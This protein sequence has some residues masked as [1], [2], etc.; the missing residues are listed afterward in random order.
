MAVRR[1]KTLPLAGPAALVVVTA[2]WA[3]LLIVGWALIYWPHLPNGFLLATEVDPAGRAGLLEAL[4]FSLVTL[5]T[6]GYGDIIPA[7]DFLRLLAPLEALVGFGLL[8]ASI[9]WVLQVYSALSQRRNLAHE[10]MLLR[11]AGPDPEALG[12]LFGDLASTVAAVRYDFLQFPIS[13]YFHDLDGRSAL[14]PVLP[15]LAD[16]ARSA[17]RR[18][19]PPEVRLRAALLRGAID[20]LAATVGSRFLDL[21]SASTDEIL[22]AYARD[23]FREPPGR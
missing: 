6:L 23:H 20:D 12:T 21:P 2:T 5:T 7:N 14:A 18:D 4:Y 8:T 3:A 10:I 22:T 11:E 9:T 1:P 16:L 15:Y 17:D 19:L 13:Y